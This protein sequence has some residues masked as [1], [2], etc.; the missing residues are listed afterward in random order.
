MCKMIDRRTAGQFAAAFCGAL[1][2]QHVVRPKFASA[3][4][5][6]AAPFPKDIVGVRIPDSDLARAATMLVQ[7]E[8]QPFLFYHCMRTF[9]LAGLFARHKGWKYDEELVFVSSAL[10][11]LGLLEKYESA[12]IRFEKAGASYAQ[13]F[14]VRGGY[15]PDRADRVWKSIAWHA[16]RV[17]PDAVPDIALIQAGAGLDV[18]AR[19]QFDEIVP[20]NIR[21]AI[22]AALPRCGFKLAFKAALAA[23]A[24]RQPAQ[25]DWTAQFAQEPPSDMVRDVLDSAWPE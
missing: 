16:G 18:F 12:N 1:A 23:H 11:D 9:V 19:P 3:Q 17:P 14:V 7:T 24:V 25:A 5:C 21:T 15:S 4:S 20:P 10:H 13:F 22:L 2:L 8:S 6:P